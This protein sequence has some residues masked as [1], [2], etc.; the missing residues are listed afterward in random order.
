[1]ELKT[2]AGLVGF[3]EDCGARGRLEMS[4]ES[5]LFSCGKVSTRNRGTV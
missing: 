1:M 2:L 4:L 5:I 3:F